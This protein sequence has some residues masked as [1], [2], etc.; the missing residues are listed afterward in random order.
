M[1]QMFRTACLSSILIVLI[2]SAP[3]YSDARD[4]L[5]FI[6]FMYFPH[7]S[8]SED[9][10][11]L[12]SENLEISILTTEANLTLPDLFKAQDT[13]MFHS[14]DYS[15]RDLSFENWEEDSTV[16]RPNRFHGVAYTFGLTH[17]M[18]DYWAI[19]GAVTPGVY[20]DFSE[21]ITSD[22]FK[23]QGLFILDRTLESG[24][25]LGFGATYTNVFGRPLPLPCFRMRSSTESVFNLDILLPFQALA[26]YS[27]SERLDLGALALMR[28]DV[29]FVKGTKSTPATRVDEL[30]YSDGTIGAHARY[31][32]SPRF[33]LLGDVGSTFHRKFDLRR[34]DE[35]VLDIDTDNTFFFRV[36]LRIT[37]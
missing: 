29:Y 24:M 35:D 2:P 25:M 17:H 10:G 15:L 14:I 31:E 34:D 21:S 3:L 22:V 1:K 13:Q 4:D 7:S 19:S 36:A 8:L 18:S 28:G 12:Q 27:V 30:R 26:T 9:T 33:F 16:Y 32:I 6:S 37:R 11:T 23:I 20:S 5:F